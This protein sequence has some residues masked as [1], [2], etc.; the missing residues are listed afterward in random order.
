MTNRIEALENEIDSALQD[1]ERYKGY[2]NIQ[3]YR[4]NMKFIQSKRAELKGLRAQTGPVAQAVRVPFSDFVQNVMCYKCKRRGHYASS[5]RVKCFRSVLLEKERL[6]GLL[7]VAK[8]ASL[9]RDMERA[10]ERRKI[11]ENFQ[12]YYADADSQ[13]DKATEGAVIDDVKV[14]TKGVDSEV[15]KKRKRLDRVL[16]N[17]S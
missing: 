7:R 1:H 14:M 5:C 2:V 13:T 8:E 9:K 3:R 4:A 17:L 10:E 12:Y 6:E 11:M 15:T 16:R